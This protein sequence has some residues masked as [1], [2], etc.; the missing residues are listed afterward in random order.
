MAERLKWNIAK[1]MIIY[2]YELKSAVTVV[3]N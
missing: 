1:K 2:K 3:V